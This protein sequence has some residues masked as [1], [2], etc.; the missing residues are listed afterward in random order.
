MV[1][2]VPAFVGLPGG[3]EMIIILAIV[4]LLFGANKL[5]SLARSSGEA[6]GEFKKGREDIEN[7]LR[8]AAGTD[9]ITDE[10]S[11]ETA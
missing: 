7:E 3:P 11:S 10:E 6:I 5:P 9:S 8:E 4:V 1:P 2:L